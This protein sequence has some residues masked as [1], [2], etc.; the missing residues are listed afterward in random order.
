[1]FHTA[2]LRNCHNQSTTHLRVFTIQ[3]ATFSTVV[4]TH[5]L[6]PRALW[7]VGRAGTLVDLLVLLLLTL[8]LL[9]LLATPLIVSCNESSKLV[10]ADAQPRAGTAGSILAA[11]AELKLNIYGMHENDA[12]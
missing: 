3:Y 11:A 8:H 9:A 5:S 6:S 2:T 12:R 4:V 1:M 10:S 7:R